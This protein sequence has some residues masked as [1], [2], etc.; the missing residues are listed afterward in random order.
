MTSSLAP[1]DLRCE[2]LENPLGLDEPHPRLSW[3]LRDERRGAR[4]R[5]WQV[6][7][8]QSQDSLKAPLWDSGRTESDQ[9]LHVVYAGPELDARTR[10]FWQVRV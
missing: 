4:Q 9:S 10:Y 5:A 6:R 2:Y 1:Y 3:K 7:V 8:A